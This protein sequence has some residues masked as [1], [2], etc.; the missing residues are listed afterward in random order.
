MQS[1]L[2]LIWP[3]K[4]I[5]LN[6][7]FA[8]TLEAFYEQTFE[9]SSKKIR[10]LKH[11]IYHAGKLG[12]Q[13]ELCWLP[14]HASIPGNEKADMLAKSAAAKEPELESCPYT[15]ILPHIDEAILNYWKQ[16]WR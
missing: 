1:N 13:T 6:P 8:R 11:A 2:Q 3:W 15:D 16:K 14:G 5:H 4:L 12:K 10:K 7:K 9:K